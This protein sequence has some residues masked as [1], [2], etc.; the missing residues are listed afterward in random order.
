[1]FSKAKKLKKHEL[2]ERFLRDGSGEDEKIPK[3][4]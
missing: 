1:M 3:Y 2:R 4:G